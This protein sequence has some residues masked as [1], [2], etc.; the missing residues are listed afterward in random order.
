MWE[1]D[2]AAWASRPL[3]GPD[4]RRDAAMVF[5]E[6]REALTLFGGVSVAGTVA[7][8]W[9]QRPFGRADLVSIGQIP[10]PDGLVTGDDFIGFINAFASASPIAD[11]VGIGGTSPPDGFVT[12]DD[13]I[14][15]INT[16][17]F[18]CP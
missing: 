17:T 5:D 11:L 1:W 14:A 13:F 18:G 15:F 6:A 3:F 10:F 7:D 12:G 9:R 8:T 4:P 2:G 16:F